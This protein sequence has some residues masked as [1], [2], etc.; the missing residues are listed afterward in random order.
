VNCW[1]CADRLSAALARD[2]LYSFI[3]CSGIPTIAGSMSLG[4]AFLPLGF[5]VGPAS[6][7]FGAATD[8]AGALLAGPVTAWVTYLASVSIGSS[9]ATSLQFPAPVTG[10]SGF[11]G[12]IGFS[13]LFVVSVIIRFSGSVSSWAVSSVTVSSVGFSAATAVVGVTSTAATVFFR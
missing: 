5:N 4:A 9:A 3:F 1:T 12:F 8:G 2:F 6:V 10:V 13:G 11:S 7:F